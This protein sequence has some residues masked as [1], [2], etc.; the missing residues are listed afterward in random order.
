MFFHA[1]FLTYRTG[2][3]FLIDDLCGQTMD[4][5]HGYRLGTWDGKHVESR[6]RE[7][8]ESLVVKYKENVRSIY[9]P[10]PGHLTFQYPDC[11]LLTNSPIQ[12]AIISIFW[13]QLCQDR[14]QTMLIM[15]NWL[16]ISNNYYQLNIQQ[17]IIDMQLCMH[18]SNAKKP[19]TFWNS[20]APGLAA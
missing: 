9:W 8:G 2:K 13:L 14:K 3:V 18:F 10:L 16:C 20:D 7:L 5:L 12:I 19:K 11:L 15:M 1:I 4:W 6:V 17:I